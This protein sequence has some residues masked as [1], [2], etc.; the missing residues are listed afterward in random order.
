LLEKKK[1]VGVINRS[2]RRFF[3]VWSQPRAIAVGLALVCRLERGEHRA[4]L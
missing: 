2:Q 1:T 4:G 3:I